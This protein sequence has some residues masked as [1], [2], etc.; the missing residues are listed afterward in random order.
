MMQQTKL[1][2]HCR[3]GIKE[4]DLLLTYYLENYYSQASCDEQARFSDL[5]TLTDSTLYAYF[6]SQQTPENPEIQQLV[7]KIKHVYS[8]A[9]TI[10]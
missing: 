1:K 5:L 2:W 9:I 4:L 3:R 10:N 6:I 8:Q 7:E